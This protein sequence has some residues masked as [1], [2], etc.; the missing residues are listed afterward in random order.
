MDQDLYEYHQRTNSKVQRLLKSKNPAEAINVLLDAIQCLSKSCQWNS[1]F[2]CSFKLLEIFQK[3]SFFS[4][5]AT[6]SICFICDCIEESVK[7]NVNNASAL[8]ANQCSK[9]FSSALLF[10]KPTGEFKNGHSELNLRFGVIFVLINEFTIAS[11]YLTESLHESSIDYMMICIK[12]DNKLLVPILVALL[13]KKNFQFSSILLSKLIDNCNSTS[14]VD[15]CQYL[16]RISLIG[17]SVLFQ[18]L[19]SY[20]PQL[21]T[22]FKSELSSLF[23]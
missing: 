18:E 10:S 5:S 2:E 14:A 8:T 16:L 20:Y 1:L 23:I 21:H 12:N 9:F 3:Y 19:L 17:N 7:S 15:F 11:K 13:K 22:E 6:A 4:E